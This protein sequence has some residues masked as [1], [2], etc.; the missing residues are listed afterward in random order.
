MESSQDVE[1]QIMQSIFHL[2][3]A[4]GIILPQCSTDNHNA[5]DSST[6]TL[7]D[8]VDPQEHVVT[9][10]WNK[11]CYLLWQRIMHRIE[12]VPESTDKSFLMAGLLVLFPT[13]EVI[14]QYQSIR[15]RYLEQCIS[16]NLHGSLGLKKQ[17]FESSVERFRRFAKKTVDMMTGD[18]E[19][20]LSLTFDEFETEDAYDTLGEIYFERLQWEVDKI[21]EKLLR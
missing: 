18:F 16:Q 5:T 8:A 7:H 13:S 2:S 6:L 3:S 11:L 14:G 19:L 20:F 17:T 9:A 21:A 10:A 4:E 12:H 15:K 1:I